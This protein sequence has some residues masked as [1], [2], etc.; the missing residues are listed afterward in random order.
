MA[1]TVKVDHVVLTL[2][3]SPAGA[4][5]TKQEVDDLVNGRLAEGYDDVEI[6]P[7][8]TNFGERSDPTDLVQLYVFK[9]Y[10]DNI[11]EHVEEAKRVGRQRKTEEP[12]TA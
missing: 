7:V 2:R 4:G 3:I 5:M 1:K 10:A 8:K 11:I 12:V 6:F 9:K